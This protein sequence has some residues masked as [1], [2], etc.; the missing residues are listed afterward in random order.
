MTDMA[1]MPEEDGHK[2]LQQIKNLLN[3]LPKDFRHRHKLKL[4]K[5]HSLL[6]EL[7][8]SMDIPIVPSTFTPITPSKFIP[9]QESST[10]IQKGIPTVQSGANLDVDS[11]L[12]T[13]KGDLIKDLK[14]SRTEL[15]KGTLEETR[16]AS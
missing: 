8:S 12:K 15:M 9:F 11:L 10:R 7:T 16:E 14:T 1:D 13:L 5:I 3:T 4:S 2:K 6:S